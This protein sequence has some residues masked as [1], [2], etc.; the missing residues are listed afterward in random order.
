MSNFTQ[1]QSQKILSC[2]FEKS[3]GSRGGKV[4]GRWPS[5]KSK[6]ASQLKSSIEQIE[7]SNFSTEIDSVQRRIADKLQPLIENIELKKKAIEEWK[8]TSGYN[9]LVK[10]F[11]RVENDKAYLSKEYSQYGN[12]LRIGVENRKKFKNLKDK[13]AVKEFELKN[14]KDNYRNKLSEFEAWLNS[15]NS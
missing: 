3:K 9:K 11:E 6:Y 2:Y 14:L 7:D 13:L 15:I 1:Q 5:G 12:T 8:S 4:V 10:L